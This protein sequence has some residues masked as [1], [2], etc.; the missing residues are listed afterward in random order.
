MLANI[1]NTK[2]PTKN[3]ASW[4][5][6]KKHNHGKKKVKNKISLSLCIALVSHMTLPLLEKVTTTYKHKQSMCHNEIT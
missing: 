5:F 3:S 2:Y 1:N 6:G 4:S